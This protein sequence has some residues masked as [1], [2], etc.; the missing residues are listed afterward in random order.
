M[1]SLTGGRL[2]REFLVHDFAR[3]SVLHRKTLKYNLYTRNDKYLLKS[4]LAAVANLNLNII[5]QMIN[6]LS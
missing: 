4:E 5:N 3:K 2:N 6:I 1:S